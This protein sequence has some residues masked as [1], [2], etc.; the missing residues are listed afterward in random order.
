MKIMM[1]SLLC[2]I[3]IF[4]SFS[5][6]TGVSVQKS[7]KKKVPK[8]K[9]FFQGYFYILELFP[10]TD[11]IANLLYSS[12]TPKLKYF[13]L[14]SKLLFYSNSKKESRQIESKYILN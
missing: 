5:E 3:I 8:G 9:V 2:L 12:K 11:A 7:K 1:I 6:I 14:N 10:G 4:C 13:T